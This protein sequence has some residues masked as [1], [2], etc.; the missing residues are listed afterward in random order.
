MKQVTFTAVAICFS[1]GALADTAPP[2]TPCPIS[3][4]DGMTAAV[5]VRGIPTYWAQD[6]QLGGFDYFEV[7]HQYFPF[8]VPSSNSIAPNQ[9]TVDM[10]YAANGTM[11]FYNVVVPTAGTYKI[12]LRYAFN[13][14]FFPGVRDR[15]EGI[16]V[17]GVIAAL[18]TSSSR[19]PLILSAIRPLMCTWRQEE[20]SSRCTIF[21]SMV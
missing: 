1:F 17:N 4:G 6:A 21:H 7:G 11:T 20:T 2:G 15:A 5:A 13:Y 9:N 12:R 14:G 16:K 19:V 10:A 8:L 3:P 18:C